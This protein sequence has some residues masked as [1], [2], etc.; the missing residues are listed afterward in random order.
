L[1]DTPSDIAIKASEMDNSSPVVHLLPFTMALGKQQK[2]KCGSGV[3]QPKKKASTTGAPTTG[4]TTI[5]AMTMGPTATA[6]AAG[7]DNDCS[8]HDPRCRDAD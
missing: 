2:A 6:V 5:G 4:T 7:R 8:R 1:L 3:H